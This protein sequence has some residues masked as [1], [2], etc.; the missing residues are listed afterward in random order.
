MFGSWKNHSPHSL[1]PSDTRTH[2]HTHISFRSC[3]FQFFFPFLFF[4]TCIP[5]HL[6]APC[7][8]ISTFKTSGI[9]LFPPFFPLSNPSL[10]PQKVPPA[11]FL[12]IFVLFSQSLILLLFCDLKFLFFLS[13]ILFFIFFLL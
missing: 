5:F 9:I 6:I 2:T 4:L 1:F 7:H 12:F 8:S 11:M 10:P 3:D 13:S